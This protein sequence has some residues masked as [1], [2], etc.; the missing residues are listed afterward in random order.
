MQLFIW[1]HSRLSLLELLLPRPAV[2][3]DSLLDFDAVNSETGLQD[4]ES[5]RS[6]SIRRHSR[7]SFL[8]APAYALSCKE[9]ARVSQMIYP[10]VRCIQLCVVEILILHEICLLYGKFC[11]LLCGRHARA[12]ENRTGVS[13]QMVKSVFASAESSL[14]LVDVRLWLPLFSTFFRIHQDSVD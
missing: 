1:P 9:N 8:S 14:T 13:S 6:V 7:T 3:L 2:A 4:W 10:I 5:G 11:F 12:R